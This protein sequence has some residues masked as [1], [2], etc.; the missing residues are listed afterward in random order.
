MSE[1]FDRNVLTE[2]FRFFAF[3][4]AV[5]R[6]GLA[7]WAGGVAGLARWLGGW[8]AGLAARLVARLGW[9]WVGILGV[10]LAGAGASAKKKKRLLG[11]GGLGG[12]GVG[13][14]WLGG[15]GLQRDWAGI[16][17]HTFNEN[18]KLMKMQ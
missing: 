17:S 7:G 15:W 4:F 2:T 14:A 6:A 10:G 18:S 13:G 9:G 12:V 3:D 16:S 8:A 5:A 11:C 1:S